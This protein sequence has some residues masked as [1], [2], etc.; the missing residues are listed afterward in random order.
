MPKV[1]KNVE[2]RW[3]KRASVATEDYRSGVQDPRKDWA[4]AAIAARDAYKQGVTQALQRGAWE[5]GVST[6]G[7]AHWARRAAEIGADRF[8]QGVAA[9]QA[10]YA[11]KVKPYLDTI[12]RMTLPPRGPKGDPRNIQ[13]VAAIAK[14]LHDQKTKGA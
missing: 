11:E 2:D 4:E 8:A 13:R 5:R 1:R 9:S 14:A 10:R 12:E 7:S 6:A 3:V